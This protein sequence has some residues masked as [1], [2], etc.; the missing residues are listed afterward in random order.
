MKDCQLIGSGIM[1]KLLGGGKIKWKAKR[2]FTTG[3][4]SVWLVVK[5]FP[6]MSMYSKGIEKC[7]LI[8]ITNA[9]RNTAKLKPI[10]KGATMEERIYQVKTEDGFTFIPVGEGKWG[11]R[12][13]IWHS[14]KEMIK[15]LEK[16]G[17][18]Y[19]TFSTK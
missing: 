4:L 14:Y 8:Q 17:I 9:K 7:G 5:V 15:D 2:F 19:K 6:T 18:K 12:D 10:S 16:W 3:H 13:I 11:D 1:V